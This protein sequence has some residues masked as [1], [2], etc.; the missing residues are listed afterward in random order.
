[1]GTR[2][3]HERKRILARAN[4]DGTLQGGNTHHAIVQPT[5]EGARDLLRRRRQDILELVRDV[6]GGDI[7]VEAVSWIREFLGNWID[8]TCDAAV[9]ALQGDGFVGMAQVFDRITVNP[10]QCGGRP[11][12]TLNQ[13]V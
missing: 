10:Q 6:Y 5:V 1:M 13:A 11:C 9:A 7:P 2:I 12:S 4:A 3:R 8:G